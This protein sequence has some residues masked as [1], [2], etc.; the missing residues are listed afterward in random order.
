MPPTNRIRRPR[1][2]MPS[3]AAAAVGQPAGHAVGLRA[4]TTTSRGGGA[5]RRRRR[6]R[7][8]PCRCRGPGRRPSSRRSRS[9]HRAAGPG[10]AARAVFPAA[11]GPG[12]NPAVGREP[13]PRGRRRPWLHRRRGMLELRA[14]RSGRRDD[15][16]AGAVWSHRCV[17]WEK[18]SKA[19]NGS[20]RRGKATHPNDP[21]P[22]GCSP[23]ACPQIGGK[24]TEEAGELVA[25]AADESR[26]PR[27]LRGRRP[28]LPHA[29]AA[30]LPRRAARPRRGRAR[31][32]VRRLGPRREGRPHR[33]PGGEPRA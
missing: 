24:V 28:R 20:S 6:A 29:R 25:A 13:G 15:S 9:R 11:V 1:D 10:R 19:S 31:P 7:A 12:E 30:R 4:A 26:R 33:R 14:R 21:T 22:A 3:T 17:G 18:P 16:R 32:P 27:R 8:S 2:R 23:A 5:P